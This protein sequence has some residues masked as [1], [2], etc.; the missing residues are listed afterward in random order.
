MLEIFVVV[1]HKDAPGRIVGYA[2]KCAI[3]AVP[4]DLIDTGIYCLRRP[5]LRGPDTVTLYESNDN[6]KSGHS[7]PKVLQILGRN[8]TLILALIQVEPGIDTEFHRAVQQTFCE[9]NRGIVTFLVRIARVD[10]NVRIDNDVLNHA[11][12]WTSPARLRV[13][14]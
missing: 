14:R 3:A 11:T 10:P 4:D 9:R 13:P 1:R 8:Q 7:S 5:T 6:L 12:S 2:N